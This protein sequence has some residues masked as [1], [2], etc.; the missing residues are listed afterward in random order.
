MSSKVS[1]LVSIG[2]HNEVI[3]VIQSL[4]NESAT[5]KLVKK[6]LEFG[7]VFSLSHVIEIENYLSSNGAVFLVENC[8]DTQGLTN[9][10]EICLAVDS[11]SYE[12][13]AIRNS[14]RF[15]PEDIIDMEDYLDEETLSQM[16]QNSSS[17]FTKDQ[18]EEL[19]FFISDDVLQQAALRSNVTL[20]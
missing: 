20:D 6:A 8:S 2:S 3:E 11:F 17:C 12:E 7:L 1:A 13:S 10:D 16:V 14:L 4:D 5:L 18:L 19:R 9:A 15:S